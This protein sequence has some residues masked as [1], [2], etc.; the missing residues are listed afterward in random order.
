MNMDEKEV[1]FWTPS[2]V[3]FPVILVG[4]IGVL[5]ILWSGSRDEVSLSSRRNATH[6]GGL[7]SQSSVVG[8]A[9]S[10]IPSRPHDSASR[11]SVSRGEGWMLPKVEGDSDLILAAVDKAEGSQ[12]MF[13]DDPK[14]WWE[15]NAWTEMPWGADREMAE[16]MWGCSKEHL[17]KETKV[18]CSTRTTVVVGDRGDGVGEVVYAATVVNEGEH[19]SPPGCAA[20]AGCIAEKAWMGR[21]APL[22][23]G[24][25]YRSFSSD[26]SITRR[27]ISTEDRTLLEGQVK[28]LRETADAVENGEDADDPINKHRV[29]MRRNSA[30][31]FE[32][33]LERDAMEKQP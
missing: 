15:T 33:L 4:I 23:T 14:T 31:Y 28:W 1:R 26:N 32:W 12:D 27:E 3:S 5:W 2:A 16:A 9:V 30:N 24:K 8:G 22:V 18:A 29:M 20:Y 6:G 25:K 11:I 13:F 19:D 17:D 21:S 7:A 10:K